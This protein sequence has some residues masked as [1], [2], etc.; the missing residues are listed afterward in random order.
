M[1]RRRSTRINNKNTTPKSID[2]SAIPEAADDKNSEASANLLE[3]EVANLERF[4]TVMIQ[5]GFQAEEEEEE[6]AIE[7]KNNDSN[8]DSNKNEDS[9]IVTVDDALLNREV[10]VGVVEDN[11]NLESEGAEAEGNLT[12]E[13][14]EGGVVEKELNLG[15]DLEDDVKIDSTKGFEGKFEEDS[16]TISRKA[17][18]ENACEIDDSKLHCHQDSVKEEISAANTK[19]MKSPGYTNDTSGI[20]GEGHMEN[21]GEETMEDEEKDEE[22]NSH[23]NNGVSAV[24]DNANLNGEVAVLEDNCFLN[25]EGAEGIV[26]CVQYDNSYVKS[27]GVVVETSLG[28]AVEDFANLDSEDFEGKINGIANMQENSNLNTEDVAVQID[29]IASKECQVEAEGESDGSKL[30]YEE[31]ALGA[32][33]EENAAANA[34]DKKSPGHTDAS[35]SIGE[36]GDGEGYNE[37]RKETAEDDENEYGQADSEEDNKED[38]DP[39]GFG[40]DPLFDQKRPKQLEIYVGGL[41]KRAVEEDLIEVFGKFGDVQAARII[42]HPTA[43]KNKG[44]GFI[45]YATVEQAINVLSELK[46]GIEVRGKRVKISASQDNNTLY[47]G[48]ICREWTKEQVLEKL[49]DY[50][51]EHIEE[52][53][54]PNDPAKEGKTK[55]FALLAFGNH[56][57]AIAAFQRLS[58]PDAVFGGDGSVKVAFAQSQMHPTAEVLSQV[59]TVYI[60]GLTKSWDAEKL[61][62]LCKQY[63]EIKEVRLSPKFRAKQ[64]VFGFVMFTSRESALACVEGINNSQIGDAKKVTGGFKV[65]KESERATG[66][67]MKGHAEPK[68]NANYSGTKRKASSDKSKRTE[69]MGKAVAEEKNQALSKSRSNIE[70]KPNKSL[71]IIADGQD[72][73]MPS[74]VEKT[75]HK[76]KKSPF[77]VDRRGKR[78]IDHDRSKRPSKR[79]RGYYAPFISSYRGHAK[80]GTS[81]SKR[82]HVDMEPHAGYLEP[83]SRKQD[84]YYAGYLEPTLKRQMRAHPGHIKPAPGNQGQPSARYHQ[85][86]QT[87]IGR[88]ALPHAGYFESAVVRQGYNA[89]NNG[90]R[91]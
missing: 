75:D 6:E 48:K 1:P 66:S 27:E 30:D 49:K 47:M 54:L 26:D 32:P 28:A 5:K 19:D 81:G 72:V 37:K 79:P 57:D 22:Q 23:I 51:I 38:D 40:D 21:N 34:E 42:K 56:S 86:P 84:Q 29:I 25:N 67:M 36:G 77:K 87:T 52:I 33:G 39:L 55:G 88:E 4:Y 16:V 91:R 31:A 10:G 35:F 14:S 60:E 44:F 15:T 85:P 74:M 80:S 69:K 12:S 70:G 41:D 73:G 43:K 17:A 65:N 62:L 76:R 45:S 64:K 59:K 50:G 2:R 58:K 46:D 61:K 24:L 68:E 90:L 7:E 8:D 20:G 71:S 89:D 78:A 9:G 53:N 63:G 83:A 11:E 82:H 3:A 18:D 13:N